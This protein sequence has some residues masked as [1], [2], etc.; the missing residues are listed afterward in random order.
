[1]T[2]HPTPTA[3][4]ARAEVRA[5]FAPTSARASLLISALGALLA[6]AAVLAVIGG[7]R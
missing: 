6:L 5:E 2:N 1:M 3:D 7:A 4:A